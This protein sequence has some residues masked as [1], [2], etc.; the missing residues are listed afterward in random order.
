MAAFRFDIE[1]Q[2]LN[3]TISGG[4]VLY[5]DD[6]TTWHALY[7]TADQRLYQAKHRGRNQICGPWN[8]GAPEQ[9]LQEGRQPSDSARAA[10]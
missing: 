6:G 9:G 10:N 3:L 8:A 2:Q 7:G 5:P 4:L 1:G